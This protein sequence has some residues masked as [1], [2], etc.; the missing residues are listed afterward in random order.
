MYQENI[1]KCSISLWQYIMH[2]SGKVGLYCQGKIILYR[3]TSVIFQI[4]CLLLMS[5]VMSYF[6]EL[7]RP[8][9][10]GTFTK[11]WSTD[12]LCG[13]SAEAR[14]EVW[15]DMIINYYKQWLFSDL[16]KILTFTKNVQSNIQLYNPKIDNCHT[17]HFPFI[18]AS[19]MSD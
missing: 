15:N 4:K 14:F 5:Y 9:K 1:N 7:I 10:T 16:T 3:T 8:L 18:F 13:C 6:V 11:I 19:E 12:K 2:W 17:K